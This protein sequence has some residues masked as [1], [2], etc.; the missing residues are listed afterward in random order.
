MNQNNNN[1]KKTQDELYN[2]WINISFLP[3]WYRLL[4]IVN[5]YTDQYDDEDFSH[6]EELDTDFFEIKKEAKKVYYEHKTEYNKQML[7]VQ[8]P[9]KK[10]HKEWIR[11]KR[12]DFLKT[13]IKELE[14]I[15]T[16]SYKIYLDQQRRDIPFWLRQV[17][18]IINKPERTTNLHKKLTNELYFLEHREELNNNTLTHEQIIHAKNYPFEKLIEVN[19][20]GFAKCPFHDDH[21]P[22]FWIKQNFGHCFSCGKS[23]DTIQFIIETQRLSFPEAVKRLNNL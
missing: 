17:I 22:S 4:K 6:L 19:K 15:I 11:Q 9:V 18:L 7:E 13:K 12:M 5:R 16:S 8:N 23:V 3:G 1:M 21:H 10:I 2:L 14:E 20:A